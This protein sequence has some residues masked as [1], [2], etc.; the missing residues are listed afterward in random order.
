[1]VRSARELCYA[2]AMIRGIVKVLLTAALGFGPV[3]CAS[4]AEELCDARCDCEYCNDRE[5]DLCVQ[6]YDAWERDA[7][8]WDCSDI[9]DAWMDCQ[10]DTWWCDRGD[11]ETS[12]GHIRSDLDRCTD[13]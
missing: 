7:D 2:R 4:S 8:Y 12:C 11:F 3:A 10:E 13:R 9:Y 5:Y 1:M 6:H